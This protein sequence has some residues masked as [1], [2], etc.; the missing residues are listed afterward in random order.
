MYRDFLAITEAAKLPRIRFHSLRHTAATSALVAGVPMHVVAK[1]LGHSTIRLT[2]DTHAA[3][4][5]VQMADAA[6]RIDA[7][8]AAGAAS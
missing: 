1:M 5:P 4:L 6:Q 2:L 8:F 7:Y 3:V